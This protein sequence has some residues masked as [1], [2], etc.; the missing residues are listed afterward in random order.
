M[1]IILED[2][3]KISDCNWLSAEQQPEV[4]GRKAFPEM[5]EI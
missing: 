2:I 1:L 3:T 4:T 5:N